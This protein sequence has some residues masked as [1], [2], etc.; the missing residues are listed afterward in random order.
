[1]NRLHVFLPEIT[2]KKLKA[3]AAKLGIPVSELVRRALQDFLA[4]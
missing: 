2:L 3:K 1:M 4:I